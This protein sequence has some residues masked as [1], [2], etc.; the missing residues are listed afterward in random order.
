MVPVICN[1]ISELHY[2]LNKVFDVR[3]SQ[4]F[5]QPVPA[6]LNTTYTDIE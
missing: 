6:D 5:P 4:P 3:N 1:Q 2:K